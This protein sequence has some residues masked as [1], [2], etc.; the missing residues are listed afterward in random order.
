MQIPIQYQLMNNDKAMWQYKWRHLVAKL[1]TYASGAIW[2]PNLE[3]M[4]VAPPGGAGLL[5]TFTSNASRPNLQPIQV[6]PPGGQN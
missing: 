4:Q 6:A 1:I 2:W 3:P 5:A